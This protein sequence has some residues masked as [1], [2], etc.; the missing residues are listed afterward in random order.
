LVHP[1]GTVDAR[2]LTDED[3]GAEVP[4]LLA[5]DAAPPGTA[6]VWLSLGT[7]S[8]TARLVALDADG[9]ALD[10]LAPEPA[11]GVGAPLAVHAGKVLAA[12]PR[13]QR[14]ELS[15]FSCAR[16]R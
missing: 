3:V 6:P 7:D 8:D 10:D 14:V 13:G 4:A 1:D 12:E 2:M 15:V 9:H 16:G 11:L 5:D